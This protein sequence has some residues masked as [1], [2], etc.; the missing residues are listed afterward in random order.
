MVG[1]NKI[2]YSG[3]LEKEQKKDIIHIVVVLI[4]KDRTGSFVHIWRTI[5]RGLYKELYRM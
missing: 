3:Q 5:K 2:K 1:Y 4:A